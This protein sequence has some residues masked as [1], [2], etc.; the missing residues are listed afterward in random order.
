MVNDCADCLTD[1]VEIIE[2]VLFS[3]NDRDFLTKYSVLSALWS[4]LIQLKIATIAIRNHEVILRLF[5]NAQDKDVILN[6][7][8]DEVS[9]VFNS[10][11]EI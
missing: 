5:T 1:G 7:Y 10:S 4:R 8:L 6:T 3:M 11:Y 2:I 9:N